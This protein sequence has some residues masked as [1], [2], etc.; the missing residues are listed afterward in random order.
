LYGYI[1]R[2]FYL[3]IVKQGVFG[4]IDI[5]DGKSGRNS[6]QRGKQADSNYR[7]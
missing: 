5:E 1:G 6:E 3:E 7:Q 2:H 4:V